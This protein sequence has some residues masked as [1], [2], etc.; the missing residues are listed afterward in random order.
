MARRYQPAYIKAA[1]GEVWYVGVAHYRT[2]PRNCAEPCRVAGERL[3]A[4]GS[5]HGI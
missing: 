1:L 2:G 3:A 5:L 4:R